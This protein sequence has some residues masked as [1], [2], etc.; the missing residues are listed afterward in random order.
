MHQYGSGWSLLSAKTSLL[1][2]QSQVWCSLQIFISVSLI[3]SAPYSFDFINSTMGIHYNEWQISNISFETSCCVLRQK[4]KDWCLKL[5]SHGIFFEHWRIVVMLI[6]HVALQFS[7][8]FSLHVFMFEKLK[9]IRE[10][11]LI[12]KIAVCVIKRRFNAICTINTFL[13]GA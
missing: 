8:I 5:I 13:Y 7:T 11:K 1:Y 4:I 6:W 12:K 3:F 9:K 10:V 2:K